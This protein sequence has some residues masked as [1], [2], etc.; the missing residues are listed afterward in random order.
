[1]LILNHP[2]M[3]NLAADFLV[4]EIGMQK[5]HQLGFKEVVKDIDARHGVEVITGPEL[6]RVS[7]TLTQ[8][9][10]L[11]RRDI[12]PPVSFSEQEMFA[13]VRFPFAGGRDGFNPVECLGDRLNLHQVD[14]KTLLLVHEPRPGS[15]L[16]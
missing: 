8:R 13:G 2:D 15:G 14:N 5:R 3:A 6:L 1:M 4:G 9:H 10:I 16:G 12:S 11:K 7:G